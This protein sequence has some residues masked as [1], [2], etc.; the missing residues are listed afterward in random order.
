MLL[1]PPETVAAEAARHDLG[2]QLGAYR[3]R[4]ANPIRAAWLGAALGSA[5]ALLALLSGVP[6][7]SVL[8]APLAIAC[9]LGYALLAPPRHGRR[10]LVV[11]E[12][13][14]VDTAGGGPP[15]VVLWEWALSRVEAG[16]IAVRLDGAAEPAQVSLHGLEPHADLVEAVDQRV[17]PVIVAHQLAVVRHGERLVFG[18]L[19]VTAE[20]LAQVADGVRLP[21][22]RFRSVRLVGADRIVIG[23][24]GAAR[25]WFSGGVP[26]APV[27][28]RVIAGLRPTAKVIM[29]DAAESHAQ[30]VRDRRRRYAASLAGLVVVALL[31]GVA[32]A[33]VGSSGDEG[34]AEPVSTP[35]VSP[36]PV[37]TVSPT[38]TLPPGVPETVYGYSAAC[39]GR[40]IPGAPPYQGPGPHPIH[41]H[42]GPGVRG[43]DHWYT[44]DVTKIQLVICGDSTTGR[45]LKKCEYLGINADDVT[46]D[47]VLGRYTFEIRE[48]RTARVVGTVRID[49]EDA[50][51]RPGLFGR[52]VDEKQQVSVP[53]GSQMEAAL[54]KYVDAYVP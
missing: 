15:R 42:D 49:G 43:P 22:E 8:V 53:F 18:P 39:I 34:T 10:W 44:E 9:G 28:A 6:L 48:A 20:G 37:S 50:Y 31:P 13:G 40:G 27:A 33:A 7:A 4:R 17:A 5:L 26:D 21:W 25:A 47:M 11:Y 3:T 54:S 52:Q 36:T 14:F 32:Y 1:R 38:P 46:Q 51:C 29:P 41:V 19:A 12:R 23:E 45:V 30:R 24:V 16:A 35:S 2:A